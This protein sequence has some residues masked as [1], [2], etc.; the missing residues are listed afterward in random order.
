[1]QW[2]LVHAFCSWNSDGGGWVAVHF[3]FCLQTIS[4]YVCTEAEVYKG[5]WAN[6]LT[7][8]VTQSELACEYLFVEVRACCLKG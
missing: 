1:M 7:F 6:H 4:L 3:Q 8:L 2:Q 5:N